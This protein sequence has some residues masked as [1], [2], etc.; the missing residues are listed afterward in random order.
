[1]KIKANVF[2]GHEVHLIGVGGIGMSAVA[3]MLHVSGVRVQGS[4][5][6]ETY[7]TENLRRLGIKIIIGHNSLN[8]KDASL[9]IRST[10]IKDDHI[11]IIEARKRNIKIMHR[12]EALAELLKGYKTV[13]ITGTHG[14]STTTALT[15][16]ICFEA[17]LRPTIINGAIINQFSSNVLIG[18]SDLAIIESD[19]SDES[20]LILPSDL[21][22]ITNMDADHLD[23]YGS[24]ANME[25]SYKEFILKTIKHGNC[26]I[27]VD[28]PKLK[29]FV[30]DIDDQKIMTYAIS[31]DADIKADNIRMDQNGMIFD[32]SFSEKFIDKF[33]LI[34][35]QEKDVFL[36]LYGNHNVYNALAAFGISLSLHADIDKIKKSLRN[37]EGVKRRFTKVGSLYGA[38]VID[39]YAHH[40]EE[41]KATLNVAKSIATMKKGKVIAVMQPHRY[42]RL[43]ALIDDF[44][45]SF[46]DADFIILADVYS[47]GEDKI[48]E[49]N[50]INLK[51]KIDNIGKEVTGICY[52]YDQLKP[53]LQKIVNVNDIIVMLGAGDITS[54]AH[55]AVK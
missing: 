20:F 21:A 41:I 19:E 44:A 29:N 28:H 38:L 7:I 1:M 25:K 6:A 22:V 27:C 12:A 14:K 34:N 37:F 47:A 49:A 17:G 48:E 2:S 46:D 52:E 9:I 36:A 5:V 13:A 16:V 51:Q 35:Q 3:Q 26:F 30:D 10:A 24:V 31:A 50:I 32:L 54:W 40:P 18:D 53:M 45:K 39:D 42:S 33:D 8:T 23:Y 15:G 11:E 43:A 55:R 4:D